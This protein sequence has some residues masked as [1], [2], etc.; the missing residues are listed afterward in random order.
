MTTSTPKAP[1]AQTMF[2]EQAGSLATTREAFEEQKATRIQNVLVEFDR[3]LRGVKETRA[4]FAGLEVD[5]DP[6]PTYLLHLEIAQNRLLEIERPRLRR[7]ESE[8]AR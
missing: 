2:Q 3:Q 5:W 6:V 4:M 8:D 1:P 7:R